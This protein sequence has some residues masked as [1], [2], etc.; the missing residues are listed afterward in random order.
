MASRALGASLALAAA[1]AIVVS[2]ASSAW[3]AGV[4]VVDGRAHEARYVSSGPLGATGCSAAG[5]CESLTMDEQTQLVG[6]SVLG[7]AALATL[8]LLALM[9]AALTVSKR[10]KG[11]AAG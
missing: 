2:I 6:Y 9:S 11:I 10:R 8:F 3:W 5:A 7:A 1:G 4:P